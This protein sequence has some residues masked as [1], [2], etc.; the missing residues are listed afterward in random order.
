MIRTMEIGRG[1]EAGKSLKR[2]R[3]FEQNLL[4]VFFVQARFTTRNMNN[5]K[6][7]LFKN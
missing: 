7:T 2:R 1:I 5:I 3:L 4:T 6:F